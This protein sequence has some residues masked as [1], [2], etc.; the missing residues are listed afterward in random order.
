MAKTLEPR[1]IE[2]WV[3]RNHAKITD[4]NYSTFSTFAE[5]SLMG[6]SAEALLEISGIRLF[7]NRQL[8]V[9]SLAQDSEDG[10]KIEYFMVHED[11]KL[12][13]RLEQGDELFECSIPPYDSSGHKPTEMGYIKPRHLSVVTTLGAFDILFENIQLIELDATKGAREISL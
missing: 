6:S 12:I 7:A 1:A 2:S 10:C 8:L 3:I 13:T 5:I 11:S 9:G 4:I